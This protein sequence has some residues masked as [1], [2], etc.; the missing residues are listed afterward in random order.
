MFTPSV[1]ATKQRYIFCII[2]SRKEVDFGPIGF[3]NM[4][5]YTVHYKD[6]A[7]VVCDSP[8]SRYNVLKE[9]PV[10][11][12]VNEKIMEKF[13]VIPM[14]F[15]LTPQDEND[16]K[17]F[18]SKHYNELKDVFLKLDGMIELGLKAYL[19]DEF[20][21]SKIIAL[22]ESDSH[23]STLSRRI[24]SLPEGKTYH[25][26]IELGRLVADALSEE[27]AHI[28]SQIYEALSCHSVDS[29]LNETTDRKMVLN[30]VFLIHRGV[31]EVFDRKVTEV[32]GRFRDKVHLRYVGPSPPYN[33]VKMEV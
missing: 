21:K 16:I 20:I 8:N 25:L 17:G 19:K 3:N 4:G 10:H 11:Q 9:G 28:A 23:V 2:Q 14:R 24:L 22:K 18:L 33:F 1:A 15:G 30:A 29:R 26:K 7:A 32:E 12:K 13:T 5:V 6:L 27:G 31:E